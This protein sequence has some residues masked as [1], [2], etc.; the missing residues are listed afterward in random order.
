LWQGVALFLW[1]ALIVGSIDNFLKP[2][3]IGNRL[4]LPILILF[5]SILGGLKL[6]GIIGLILGPMIVTLLIALLDL[7]MKE[8]VKA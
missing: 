8:Y 4:R 2:L 6:F 5:F 3:L 1:G 7:Y